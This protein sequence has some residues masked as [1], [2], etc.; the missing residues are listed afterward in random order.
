MWDRLAPD[1]VRFGRLEP[2]HAD[3]FA[4]YCEAVSDF[5]EL[6][7]NIAMM[8]RTYEVETRNG[9]QQKKTADWQARQDAIMIMTR[10]GALFGMSPV[11][12]QRLATDGQGDLF[13]AIMDKLNGK[14]D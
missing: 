3:M 2:H 14:P 10:V 5:I 13:D 7:S 4:V 11:D 8:G 1:M 6:T 9:R 12:D